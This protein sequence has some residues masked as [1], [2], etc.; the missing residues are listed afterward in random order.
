MEDHEVPVRVYASSICGSDLHILRGVLDAFM[1]RGHSRTGHELV[2]EFVDRGGGVSDLSIGDR[3][4]MGYSCS[5][6]SRHMCRLGQTVHYETTNNT[7]YGFGDRFGDL[8]GTHAEC[9]LLPGASTHTLRVPQ[10][11]DTASAVTLSCNLPSAII[12]NALVDIQPGEHVAVVGCGPT[13]L[14]ALQLAVLRNPGCLVAINFEPY[15]LQIA[16]ASGAVSCIPDA[17]NSPATALKHTGARGFDKVIEMVGTADSLLTALDLVRPGGTSCFGRLYR[18][19]VQ[20]EPRGRL[21]SRYQLTSARFRECTT[22]NAIAVGLRRSSRWRSNTT[23]TLM[24][25]APGWKNG[26]RWRTQRSTN[27][28]LR[29]RE[30][31]STPGPRQSRRRRNSELISA[32]DRSGRRVASEHREDRPRVRRSACRPRVAPW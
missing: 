30:R 26:Y 29:S 4:T 21:S 3:V 22:L 19:R 24:Y 25:S 23:A 13:G 7:V 27:F 20:P 18:K 17:E 32:S 2:C 1:R 16:A 8:N 31:A 6:G 11:I 14:M 5:C 12:A 9:I 28:V 15:R 10:N